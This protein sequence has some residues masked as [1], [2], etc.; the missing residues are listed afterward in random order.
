MYGQ[1]GRIG[2]IIPADNAVLEPEFYGMAPEGVSLN[3]AR[4]PKSPRPEMPGNALLAAATLTHARVNLVSYM[5]AASSFILGPERNA[6]LCREMSEAAGGL[7]SFTATTAMVDALRAVGATRV[8]VLAPHPPDT[9]RSLR[10]YLEQ[11]GFQVTDVDALGLPLADINNTRPEQILAAIR[12]KD[13]SQA[14]SIFIAATNFRAIDVVDEI[15]Q[16]FGMPVVTSNQCS[17]WKA[18]Q[19]LN[20]SAPYERYGQLLRQ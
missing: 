4:L 11:S 5:C 19:I 13:L 2:A 16:T 14:D 18:L 8:S 7:P 9:A 20:V 6:Q 1:R 3:V 17:L 12:A 10:E 15:E